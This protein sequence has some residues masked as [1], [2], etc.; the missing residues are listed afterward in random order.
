MAGPQGLHA[1]GMLPSIVY[2][3]LIVRYAY[4]VYLTLMTQL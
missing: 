1:S 3:T 4:E 2:K